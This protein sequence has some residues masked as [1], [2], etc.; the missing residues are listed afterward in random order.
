MNDEESTALVEGAIEWEN[1]DGELGFRNPKRKLKGSKKM[2]DGIEKGCKRKSMA[3]LEAGAESDDEAL[4][5]G[6]LF[7]KKARVAKKAKALGLEIRVDTEKENPRAEEKVDSGE[8]GDTLASFRKRLKGPRK[9]KDVA[10]DGSDSPRDSEVKRSWLGSGMKTQKKGILDADDS[11]FAFIRKAQ[12]ASGRK[13]RLGSNQKKHVKEAPSNGDGLEESFDRVSNGSS[14]PLLASD[15]IHQSNVGHRQGRKP[16]DVLVV[17]EKVAD[18]RIDEVLD[19]NVD[20]RL[21]NVDGRLGDGLGDFGKS[22]SSSSRKGRANVQESIR[23]SSRASYTKSRGSDCGS[24]DEDG[25][26][27]LNQN[28]TEDVLPHQNKEELQSLEDGLKHCSNGK[29]SKS[30]QEDND[31]SMNDSDRGE[32]IDYVELKVED[33]TENHA[34]RSSPL[35]DAMRKRS[36]GNCVLHQN[37][38]FAGPLEMSE[39]PQINPPS[40]MQIKEVS[41]SVCDY[42]LNAYCSSTQNENTDVNNEYPNLPS[43]EAFEKLYAHSEKLS[44]VSERNLTEQIEGSCEPSKWSPEMFKASVPSSLDENSQSVVPN[45]AATISGAP[46]GLNELSNGQVFS[47]TR[48]GGNEDIQKEIDCLDKQRKDGMVCAKSPLRTSNVWVEVNL[49]SV[50]GLPQSSVRDLLAV[51]DQVTRRSNILSAF[52][53]DRLSTSSDSLNQF[54][55]G[56]SS[57]NKPFDDVFEEPSSTAVKEL[58]TNKDNDTSETRQLDVVVMSD[59]ETADSQSMV[60]RP[61]RTKKHRQSEMT[62]EGDDDWEVLTY[63]RGFLA[64]VSVAKGD[65]SVRTKQKP[66]YSYLLGEAPFGDTAAVAVGLKVSAAGPIEKIKFKEVLKRKGGLQ[67]YLSCRNSILELWSKDVKHV[68]HAEDCGVSSIPVEDESP[69]ESLVREIFLFLDSHGYINAGIASEQEK[70][71][72]GNLFQSVLLKE[73]NSKET[74][75]ETVSCVGECPPFLAQ[76]TV[77]QTIALMKDPTSLEVPEA[78]SLLQTDGGKIGKLTAQGVELELSAQVKS[79]DHATDSIEVDMQPVSM[80]II[81]LPNGNSDENNV[82]NSVESHTN[83]AYRDHGI[84]PNGI[85]RSNAQEQGSLFTPTIPSTDPIANRDFGPSPFDSLKPM[86][87]TQSSHHPF[88]NRGRECAI[89]ERRY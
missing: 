88:R 50:C 74:T 10:G 60:L 68:L 1:S 12:S 87:A 70:P 30:A 76:N 53:C 26:A 19:W 78:A 46:D 69:R 66:N 55:Q 27:N 37:L 18:D 16:R 81:Q 41:E 86:E 62:H 25:A 32:K 61:V 36:K 84:C 63:Q 42:Q 83:S 52:N 14:L 49:G 59:L 22:R 11:L 28:Y 5:I 80:S 9:L 33:I 35:K 20:G 56:T 13:S 21:G 23:V 43:E 57:L 24:V 45:Q 47:M 17:E 15:G 58:V 79:E 34:T 4:P 38:C 39:E 40:T 71:Q 7:K 73:S 2:G 44:S 54:V 89:T 48:H 3:S 8:L 67:E 6:S 31:L 65:C 64:D 72:P 51:P 75:G 82:R 77:S 29:R 85:E